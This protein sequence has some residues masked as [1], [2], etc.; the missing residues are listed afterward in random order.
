MS[1]QVLLGEDEPLLRR[2][3][4]IRLEKDGYEVVAVDNGTE[5]IKKLEERPFDL[6]ITDIM[7]P[8][9]TGLEIVSYVRSHS[10]KY[11]PIIILSS[12]AMESTILE[13][14]S[15]GADDFINKPF[16]PNELSVRVKRLLARTF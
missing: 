1:K 8:F 16:S 9:M 14:F 6:I 3:I 5:V 15:L 7:M 13:A 10:E 12:M 2:L 11:I 4:G